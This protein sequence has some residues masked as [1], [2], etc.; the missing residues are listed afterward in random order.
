MRI[1]MEKDRKLLGLPP[2]EPLLPRA[3]KIFLAILLITILASLVG[4]ELRRSRI[5]SGRTSLH[6]MF[7]QM[8]FTA[9]PAEVLRLAGEIRSQARNNTEDK[10]LAGHALSYAA[11]YAS[12]R[13]LWL[14][15]ALFAFQTAREIELAQKKKPQALDPSIGMMIS[16]VL[17]D[18]GHERL[19]LETAEALRMSM[20]REEWEEYT[21]DYENMLAYIYASAKSPH[22]RDGQK[23]VAIMEKIIKM[24]DENETNS[25]YLDTLA[26]SYYAAGQPDKAVLTQRRAL[27]GAETQNLYTFLSHYEKYEKAA[28][29]QKNKPAPAKPAPAPAKPDAKPVPISAKPETKPIPAPAKP[30][31]KPVPVP[32]KPEAKPS[33]AVSTKPAAPTKP[34]A[35][36]TPPATKPASQP[37]PVKPAPQAQPT[38]PAPA[39]AVKTQ[40][41]AKPFTPT[42]NTDPKKPAGK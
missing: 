20:E 16:G 29:A 18:L 8:R 21:D 32:A 24:S 25:A 34:V 19:A 23:A 2:K 10:T 5:D 12:D 26:E 22:I 41:A 42:Q 27:A 9:D 17:L 14:N 31:V 30:E 28:L 7:A 11:E 4:A 33:P 13:E 37:A 35:P 36:A 15:E 39:S 38:K 1:D 6:T 3:L 40:P